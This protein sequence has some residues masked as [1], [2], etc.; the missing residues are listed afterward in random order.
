MMN[1]KFSN[2]IWCT[3]DRA[4]SSFLSCGLTPSLV[5]PYQ[6]FQYILYHSIRSIAHLRIIA[7]SNTIFNS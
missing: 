1:T 6:D 7:D 4:H 3:C 5:D 2:A